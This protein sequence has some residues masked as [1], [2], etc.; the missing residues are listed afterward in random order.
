MIGFRSSLFLT[1]IFSLLWAN[2]EVFRFRIVLFM[3]VSLSGFERKIIN[4]DQVFEVSD[5][6]DQFRGCI[7]V[8][9]YPA[10]LCVCKKT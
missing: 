8:E 4:T 9:A 2:R 5:Y 1:E 3:T 10:G 7:F 6:V